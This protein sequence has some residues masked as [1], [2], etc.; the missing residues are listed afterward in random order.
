MILFFCH[1]NPAK[2]DIVIITCKLQIRKMTVLLND[3]LKAAG[4]R[5]GRAETEPTKAITSETV[6]LMDPVS[7]EAAHSKVQ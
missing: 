2:L 4:L 7:G 5:G 3:S 6:R 1:I